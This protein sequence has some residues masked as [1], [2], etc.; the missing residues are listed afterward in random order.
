M[1][2][3]NLILAILGCVLVIGFFAATEIAFVSANRLNIELKK[4][5]GTLTGRILGRFVEHP[6]EYIGAS[7]VGVNIALVIY[8]VLMAYFTDKWI[9]RLLPPFLI[10]NMYALLGLHTVIAASIMILF[11]QFIPKSIFQRRAESILGVFAAPMWLF[12]QLLY[13]VAR[14]FVSISE[15][16]LKYLFNV[17]IRDNHSVF[18]R[19]NLDAF[20]RQSLRGHDPEHSALNKDLFANALDLVNVKVRKCIVPRKE[21]IAVSVDASVADVREK[22]IRTKRSKVVV[23]AQ[24]IDN[25]VGYVHHLDFNKRPATIRDMLHTISAVPESM[26]AVDLMNRFTRERK[27]IAWVIDE[28]GGT[29]GI[30]TMEDLLEEIFGEIRDEFDVEEYVDK[31]IAENEYL[32]SGRIKLDYLNHKYGF[33][34]DTTVA[35]TLSGYI[36]YRYESI[37]RMRERIISGLHEFEILLVSDTRVETVKLKVLKPL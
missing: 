5:Q 32:F 33:D 20:V 15:F 1:D 7:L 13:P 6:G 19:V 10:G 4:K 21:I 2:I 3:P 18:H 34:F 23:Y 17:R 12:F 27:S 29:A 16:I 8:A 9:P 28:F 37:P 24:S 26:S 36:I 35:E 31:Q 11:A 14:V 22:F 25:I 30:V